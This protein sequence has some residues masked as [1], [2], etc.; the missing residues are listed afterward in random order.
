MHDVDA[1]NAYDTKQ[2]E[3]KEEWDTF[4]LY[5]ENDGSSKILMQYLT[6]TIIFM[7]QYRGIPLFFVFVLFWYPMHCLHQ[8]HAYLQRK[9]VKRNIIRLFW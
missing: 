4:I 3:N 8:R 6:G 1:D 9:H 2:Y 7:L 5:H